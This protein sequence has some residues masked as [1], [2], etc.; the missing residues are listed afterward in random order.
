M[1]SLVSFSSLLSFW[2]GFFNALIVTNNQ[3]S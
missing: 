1:L 2:F 3:C